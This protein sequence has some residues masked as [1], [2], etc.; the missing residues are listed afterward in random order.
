MVPTLKAEFS[1]IQKVLFAIS[2]NVF[3]KDILYM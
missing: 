2:G 1:V 3:Y